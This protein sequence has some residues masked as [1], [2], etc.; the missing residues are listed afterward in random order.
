MQ[1]CAAC[2]WQRLGQNALRRHQWKSCPTA[3]S[4]EAWWLLKL[5]HI[6]SY[7]QVVTVDCFG[8][9]I[10]SPGVGRGLKLTFLLHLG[11]GSGRSSLAPR[12]SPV[13]LWAKLHSHYN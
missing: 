10:T 8:V 1:S 2:P 4:A 6:S 7:Q 5:G 9:Y 3:A 11:P 12:E 13:P